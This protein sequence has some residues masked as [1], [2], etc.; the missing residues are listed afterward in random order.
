MIAYYKDYKIE[1]WEQTP[2]KKMDFDNN[3]PND[4]YGTHGYKV[5]SPQGEQ[6]HFDNKD[7]W[8]EDACYQ[9]ACQEIDADLERI[10]N[11]TA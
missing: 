8:D 6:I 1:I 2:N 3:D 11:D 7:T 9:N 5:F 10:K 4:T